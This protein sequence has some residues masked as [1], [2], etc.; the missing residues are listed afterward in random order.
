VGIKELGEDGWGRKEGK[1][2]H[3]HILD[4]CGRRLMLAGSEIEETFKDVSE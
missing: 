1:S 2:S 3:I 4:A